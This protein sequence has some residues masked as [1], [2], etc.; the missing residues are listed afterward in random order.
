M[1]TLN[2]SGALGEGGGLD[3]ATVAGY[4][5]WTMD[6]KRYPVKSPGS[7]FETLITTACHAD[8][9]NLLR[10]GMG[11]PLVAHCVDLYKNH[12]HGI[13]MLC[14]LAGVERL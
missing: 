7:F 10:I 3:L 1:S 8:R 13:D 6:S 12:P 5:L 9:D 4:V 2:F 11:F 14:Q